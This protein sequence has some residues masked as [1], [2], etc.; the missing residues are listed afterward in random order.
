VTTR[1]VIE[2]LAPSHDR[3]S[4]SSGVGAL[5]RYLRQF[6]GQ[7]ARKR[8]ANCFVAVERTSGQLAGFYT[9]SATAISVSDLPE[10]LA[11]RLPHYPHVPAALIGRLAVDVRHRGL[12]LGEALLLDAVDRVIDADPAVFALVVDAKD[13]A[14]ASFYMR[15]E[16]VRLSTKQMSFFLPVAALSARRR[17]DTAL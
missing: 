14:A 1:F 9:L 2:R 12:R 6:A 11:K 7:D 15:Y 8:L 10:P 5:D 17:Q 3:A 16:F 13:E 4:F